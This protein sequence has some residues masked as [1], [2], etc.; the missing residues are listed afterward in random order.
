M[1]IDFYQTRLLSPR[2][3]VYHRALCSLPLC[4]QYYFTLETTLVWAKHAHWP[5]SNFNPAFNV[6]MYIYSAHSSG[7]LHTLTLELSLVFGRRT[8]ESKMPGRSKDLSVYVG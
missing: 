5:W 6:S 7:T 2:N 8:A 4:I 1:S 3:I